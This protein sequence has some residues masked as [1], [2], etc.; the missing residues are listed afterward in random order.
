MLIGFGGLRKKYFNIFLM[1][2]F[3]FYYYWIIIG[4]ESSGDKVRVIKLFRVMLK[5]VIV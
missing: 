5:G 3:I 4:V 1:K 2:V